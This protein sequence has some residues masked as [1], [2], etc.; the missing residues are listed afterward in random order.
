MTHSPDNRS[1]TDNSIENLLSDFAVTLD[2]AEVSL[3]HAL[4]QSNI[5]TTRA[6]QHTMT[7]SL[8]S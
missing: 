7:V 3:G 5:N 8:A 1:N 6:N 2:S 4:G